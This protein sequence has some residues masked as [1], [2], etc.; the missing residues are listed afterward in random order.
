MDKYLYK[1]LG[2]HAYNTS[3]LGRVEPLFLCGVWGLLFKTKV[4]CKQDLEIVHGVILV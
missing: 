2:V 3:P 1:F 4:T